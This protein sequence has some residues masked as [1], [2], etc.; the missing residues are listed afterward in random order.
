VSPAPNLE[1][2]ARRFRHAADYFPS[3]PLYRQL[4]PAVA[5]DPELLEIA[6]HG[7]P[8]QHEVFLFFGAVHYLLARNPRDPAARHYPDLHAPADDSDPF[9]AFRAFC[10]AH[11]DELIDLVATHLVQT[12]EPKRSTGL[13][14][15]LA[16]VQRADPRPV[17]LVEVGASAGLN[18]LF[19]RYAYDFGPGGIGGVADSSVTIACTAVGDVM[20]PVP[21]AVP[22]VVSR[23]GI[24]LDPVDVRDPEAVE[25]LKALLSPE[26]TARVQLLTAACQAAQ[27]GPPEL[28]GGDVFDVL[29]TV[30]KAIPPGVPVCLFHSSV[31]FHFPPELRPRF[32]DMV[33]E[34]ARDHDVHWLS[35]EGA[36]TTHDVPASSHPN[37][38]VVGLTSL[39]GG[40][41]TD[42]VLALFDPHGN[43][44]EWLPAAPDARPPG[45]L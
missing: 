34:L 9:P 21:D 42:R 27:S 7:R 13:L 20:P 45:E 24:D 16:E 41:R 29:P 26:D 43:W 33:V 25:W 17:A 11:R 23:V 31:I 28:V 38:Q 15:G 3:S 37:F 44:I 8:G 6:S 39:S 2:L 32:S 5:D 12:N 36:G 14:L 4:S 1:R 18:L 10:A 35:V 30:V 19:D 22:T 40:H